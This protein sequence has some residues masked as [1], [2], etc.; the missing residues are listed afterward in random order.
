MSISREWISTDTKM[1]KHGGTGKHSR[2]FN[3]NSHVVG[4]NKHAMRHILSC[5]TRYCRVSVEKL[6]VHQ[7]NRSCR[8]F[9]V[10]LSYAGVYEKLIM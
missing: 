4:K 5:S 8:T 7:I 6:C 3:A 2:E 10:C 1:R 9:F